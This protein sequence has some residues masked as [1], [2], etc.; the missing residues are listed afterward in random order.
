RGARVRGRVG[1]FGDGGG[2][3]GGRGGVGGGRNER[4]DDGAVARKRKHDDAADGTVTGDDVDQGE[5]G[6]GGGGG[7]C[8]GEGE[9]GFGTANFTLCIKYRSLLLA[10]FVAG[11]ELVVVEAPWLKI[12]GRLPDTLHRHRFGT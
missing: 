9:G 11:G 10:D 8:G 2:K 5:D 1:R 4:G 12:V 3:G 7:G 6:S